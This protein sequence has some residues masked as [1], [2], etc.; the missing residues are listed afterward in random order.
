MLY[1]KG[2]IANRFAKFQLSQRYVIYIAPIEQEFLV[3]QEELK[4]KEILLN[5]NSH[6][7]IVYISAFHT[8][9]ELR[10]PNLF[11]HPKLNVEKILLDSGYDY[12]II[13]LPELFFLDSTDI[14]LVKPLMLELKN[15]K[16]INLP[17]ECVNL[18]DIDNAFEIIN[19]IL[20]RNLAVNKVINVA[21]PFNTSLVALANDISTLFENDLSFISP[22]KN[23]KNSI[24]LTEE[25]SLAIKILGINFD[26][27]YNSRAVKKYYSNIFY[28]K[29]TLSIIIPTYNQSL[30]I[31]EFYRRLK[32][33]L[34]TLSERFDHE[35]IFINDF[36]LDETLTRLIDIANFDQAV[37]IINFS[38]NFGNQAAIAAGIEYCSGDVAVIIDDDLQDPPEIILDFIA[39]WHEG[40]KV[41][42]G[43]RSER[44]NISLTFKILAKIHYRILG[45]LSETKIPN[46]VG[47]FRLIDKIVIE[48]LR[49]FT[50]ENL[51]YRGMVAWVG[52]KQIGLTYDRDQRYAG[53][54]NFSYKKYINFAI[55]GLTSFTDRPLFF[56]GAIGL[57]ISVGAFFL[58]V[59]LIAT[60]I[61]NPNA[62]IE[63]WTSLAVI[64]LF[65]GGVQLFSV[66]I[67]GVYISKIYR[68]VKNRPIF[69]IDETINF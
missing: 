33:V 15:D 49:L 34:N 63:G 51:Y 66:G 29:S 44:Q 18:L 31:N 48:N 54:S 10:E 2:P 36:S 52:Y 11:I 56:S 35:M 42:Y 32:L 64:I 7:I 65:F 67:L 60:R 28:K 14:G 39:K 62:T 55:N 1:G 8:I 5:A 47:D 68:Q 4:L 43:I 23:V 27:N 26:Q 59:A 20:K 46:D 6:Q 22:I 58:A 13:K 37:K 69:L 24:T 38:R 50:E 16:T 57:F 19:Y 41:V 9:K 3:P 25:V 53:K 12:V 61:L 40:Y 21:C 30:G 17:D 45:V